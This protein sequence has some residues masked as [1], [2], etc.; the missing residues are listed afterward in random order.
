MSNHS[1]ILEQLRDTLRSQQFSANTEKAFTYWTEAYLDYHADSDPRHLGRDAVESFMSHLVSE[2]FA[3]AAIQN[4]ALQA[5]LF[6]YRDVLSEPTDWLQSFIQQRARQGHRNILSPEE[7][8]KLLAQLQAPQWL[9]AALI[10]GAGLRLSETLRLRIRDLNLD[11]RYLTVRHPN[12]EIKRHTMLPERLLDSLRLHLEDRRLLHIKDIADGFGEAPL[13]RRVA[14]R[15]A[16]AAR[17]WSWQFLFPAHRRGGSGDG[18]RGQHSQ[19]PH[20][21][22]DVVRNAIGK[23]AIEAGIF[24]QVGANT[25]RNSFAVQL[26]QLG[27]PTQQVETLLGHGEGAAEAD[28]APHLVVRSPLDLLQSH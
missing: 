19:R 27:V 9:V 28:N 21:G 14:A 10:Y 22:E 7:C 18:R 17:S 12:G 4:Q 6:L 1:N 16:S 11:N 23:A 24:K 15:D 5:L 20:L 2:R 25:L 8:Q 3:A 13:P 26:I